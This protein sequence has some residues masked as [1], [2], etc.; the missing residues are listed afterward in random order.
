MN[1]FTRTVHEVNP[2]ALHA[3][4]IDTLMVNVGL[5][6]DQACGHCHQS[7][8]PHRT[9]VMS[10]EVM[11][12]VAGVAAEVRPA[13]VDITGGAPELNPDIRHLIGMLRGGGHTVRLRTNLT[14]LL[15]PEATGL[16]AYLAN[17]EVAI[18]ASV[19]MASEAEETAG[20]G[21]DFDRSLVALRLLAEAGFGRGS[22]LRLDIAVNPAGDM[23]P[24]SQAEIETRLRAELTDS[25]GIAFDSV[26]AITNVPVGRF[27][28]WLRRGSNL[29]SYLRKLREAFN[30]ETLTHLA[31]R[32]C[33]EIAWDG[34]L[35]DCDFHLGHGVALAPGMP[36]HVSEF[37][38]SVLANRPVRF[39]EHCFAC[40]AMAGSG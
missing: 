28:E 5:R 36:L 2:S 39:A 1:A 10:R 16:V 40:T 24:V 13:L 18:L 22:G 27:R 15:S 32:T 21:P 26:L 29:D 31:C 37:D 8:S 14:A 12:A 33:I 4:R 20:R 9:E 25:H 38:A 30:P 35:W 23:G 17:N 6:C 3:Q 19:P 11:D 34:T 7:S